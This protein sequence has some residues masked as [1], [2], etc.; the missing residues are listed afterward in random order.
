LEWQVAGAAIGGS[1]VV[2]ASGRSF[3][4]GGGV[5]GNARPIAT[6]S[7]SSAHRTVR[8]VRERKPEP[9]DNKGQLACSAG[10]GRRQ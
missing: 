5:R 8:F 6:L 1:A 4:E 10:A 7:W 3:V 2:A 9:I